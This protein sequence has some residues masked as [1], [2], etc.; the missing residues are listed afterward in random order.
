MQNDVKINYDLENNPLQIKTNSEV[1]SNEEAK[2]KF[3]SAQEEYAGG[4]SLI[5]KSPPLYNIWHCSPSIEFLTELPSDTD[6]IWTISLKRSTSLIIVIHCNDVEVLN[7]VL[8]D[9]S[10]S[11]DHEWSTYW[12]R[13]VEKIE[14]A[15]FNTAADYYRPGE[16]YFM[17][18]FS[19][20]EI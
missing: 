14:F 2:I 4:I 18:T 5:Y 10:C 13:E 20:Q 6:K 12:T 7:I 11:N 9:T 16:D 8:S 3:F 1:G 17:G 15:T 19:K